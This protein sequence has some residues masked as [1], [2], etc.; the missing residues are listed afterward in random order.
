MKE[1]EIANGKTENHRSLEWKKNVKRKIRKNILFYAV[2]YNL[3]ANKQMHL[4]LIFHKLTFHFIASN[5]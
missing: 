3:L 2:L 1:K 4:E 5:Q